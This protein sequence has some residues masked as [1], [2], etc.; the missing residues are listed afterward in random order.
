MKTV[1]G[2]K[3]MLFTWLKIL[4]SFFIVILLFGV[5]DYAMK[6]NIVPAMEEMEVNQTLINNTMT[7]WD[8]FPFVFLLSLFIVG[9]M[10][11][12]LDSPYTRGI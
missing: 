7:M 4:M 3:G 6:D 12:M 2:N 5:F 11:A 1:R 9:L 8:A 10:Y